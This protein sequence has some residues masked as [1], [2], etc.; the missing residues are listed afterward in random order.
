VESEISR[1]CELGFITRRTAEV[2]D[3]GM[4]SAFF[5]SRFFAH[6][7]EAERVERELRFARFIPLADLTANPEFADALG[8][9][10]LFVQGSIDLLCFYPD[11]HVELCD[12]KTD[13]ITAEERN[14]PALLQAHMA[15]KHRNQIRQYAAAVEE[16]YGL[17]PTK[18]Y[19]FSLPLGE[20]VEMEV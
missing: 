1:L 13:H 6:V 17:R 14:D 8:D 5:G 20:A 12:Y 2:L 4:L 18:A 10:T 11:G 7:R 16:T 19:I 15:D 3:R 9:R